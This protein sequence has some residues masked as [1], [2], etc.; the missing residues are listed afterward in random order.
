LFFEK[1]LKELSQEKE[2][3][4]KAPNFLDAFV[5]ITAKIL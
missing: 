5:H 4:K 2:N 3:K 1:I